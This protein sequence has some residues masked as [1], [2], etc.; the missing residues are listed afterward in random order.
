M[1]IPLLMAL[2]VLFGALVLVCLLVGR[3]YEVR[4]KIGELNEELEES[5]QRLRELP[6]DEIIERSNSEEN[7]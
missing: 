5:G 6:V 1:V 7:K 3:M 2:A 4:H